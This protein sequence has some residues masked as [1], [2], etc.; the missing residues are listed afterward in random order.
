MTESAVTAEWVT[1]AVLGRPRGNRG[2]VTATGYSSHPDRYARLSTVHLFGDGKPYTLEKVWTHDGRLVF[3]FQGVDCISEAELLRGAEVRV[4][5]AE[6][7]TLDDGEF[8]LADLVGCELRDRVS[9]KLYG[10]VTG[11]EEG[12]AQ[13]LLDID[14]GKMLVPFVKA[15]C[16]EIHPELGWIKVDLPEGLDSLTG[17]A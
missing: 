5:K 3:K 15:I 2:E 16:T 10:K 12:G 17:D 14:D 9:D 7:L 11:W 4:P 8:F 1:V 13:V 6:R